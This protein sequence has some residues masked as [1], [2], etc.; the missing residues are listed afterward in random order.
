[1]ISDILFM[2]AIQSEEADGAGGG[3]WVY[4]SEVPANCSLQR[5]DLEAQQ[6]QTTACSKDSKRADELD[7]LRSA[8]RSKNIQ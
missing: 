5:R 7:G 2:L 3:V 8:A 1:M 4:D 6:I